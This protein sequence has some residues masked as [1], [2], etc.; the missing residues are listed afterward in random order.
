MRRGHR[1]GAEFVWVPDEQLLAQRR[2]PV[3]GDAAVADLPGS[4]AGRFRCG[5][6]AWPILPAAGRDGGGHLVV[7]AGSGAGSDD[8]RAGEIGISP[9]RE[10]QILACVA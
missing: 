4:M 5:S 9:E 1:A 3:V 6:S 7:D 8:E 10:Q 2:P